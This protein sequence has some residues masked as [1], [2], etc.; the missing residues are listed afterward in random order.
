MPRKP[1]YFI[2][3]VPSH[4]VV[5]GHN[6][7]PCFIRANDYSF[8]LRSLRGA[9]G[10]GAAHIHAYVLMTNHIHLLM[11]PAAE[12]AIPWVLQS[13][14]R[15]YVQYI[16]E[17]YERSGTLWEGRYKASLIDTERYLL[18]CYRYIELNPVRAGMVRSPADYPWSSFPVNALGKQ[19]GVVSAHEGYLA[20]GQDPSE[21]QFAYRRLI[22]EALPE[23]DL[24]GLRAATRRC[25]PLGSDQFKEEVDRRLRCRVSYLPVGRPWGGRRDA[26][27]PPSTDHDEATG[28]H[29]PK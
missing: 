5:R 29:A 21:R 11:T 7:A 14:G 15:R 1:R 4:I 13:V 23:E 10:R 22:A 26:L 6:R 17:T 19:D 24:D 8:F 25:I 2:P 20:L 18:T 27:C 12:D 3:G 9:C 16:N 28:A